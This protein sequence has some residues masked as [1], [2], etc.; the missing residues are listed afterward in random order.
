MIFRPSSAI[1]LSVPHIQQ[2]GSG[3]CLAACAAMCLGYLASPVRYDQLLKA[4]RVRPRLG[5]PFSNIS[6]LISLGITVNYRKY[7]TLTELYTFLQGGWPCVVSVQTQELPYWNKVKVYHAV[8]VAG[9]DH[10]NIHLND[11]ALPVGPIP[12]PIGDF[13]LAWLAQ[14]ETYAI[15]AP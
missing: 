7:G 10:D 5:A 15:L 14:D 2:H 4:L 1:L 9:M 11:P 6:N 8:V 13:D 3:E 12:V